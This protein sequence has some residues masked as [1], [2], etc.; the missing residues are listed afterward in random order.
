MRR[1]L[2]GNFAAI[3]SCFLSE[4]KL[5]NVADF[6]RYFDGIDVRKITLRITF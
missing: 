4:K 6:K 3:N 2:L 1:T 5:R